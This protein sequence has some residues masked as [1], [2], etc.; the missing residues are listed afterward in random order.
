MALSRGQVVARAGALRRLRAS[1][2]GH[3]HVARAKLGSRQVESGILRSLS[4][5]MLTEQILANCTEVDASLNGGKR[6]GEKA[7]SGKQN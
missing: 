1:C 7:L 6:L 3:R 5:S 2:L 4:E